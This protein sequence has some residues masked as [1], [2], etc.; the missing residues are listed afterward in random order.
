MIKSNSGY[1]GIPSLLTP[2]GKSRLRLRCWLKT[3]LLSKLFWFRLRV[4][5]SIITIA[6]I[7][8]SCIMTIEFLEKLVL[9]TIYSLLEIINMV[10]NGQ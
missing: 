3:S 10:L 8:W 7:Y 9:N 2:H 5:A 4:L 6:L 1:F